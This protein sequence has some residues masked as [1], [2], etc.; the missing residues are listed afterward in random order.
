MAHIPRPASLA[1]LGYLAL[2][3]GEVSRAAK[4]AAQAAT[5]LRGLKAT[6]KIPEC[7]EVL[8]GVAGARGQPERAAR[9]FGAAEAL[10]EVNGAPMNTADRAIYSRSVATARAGLSAT[11]LTAAWSA[12]RALTVDQAIEEALSPT[13]AEAASNPVPKRSAERP[14]EAAVGGLTE[15]EREVA[16]LVA[17]GL[18]NKQ[19]AHELVISPGTVGVHVWHILAKLLRQ[20]LGLTH[21]QTL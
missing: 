10:R 12:G 3:R 6:W 14:D 1:V 7:L 17:R 8:A 9:L 20:T 19:V 5:L 2:D 11:A 15:R 21:R 4:I 18:S 13:S 16:V